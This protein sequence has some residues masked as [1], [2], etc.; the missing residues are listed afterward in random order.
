MGR[1]ERLPN[2][3]SCECCGIFKGS[4]Q[5]RH[6]FIFPDGSQY[7]GEWSCGQAEG[8]GTYV[9]SSGTQYSGQFREGVPDGQGQLAMVNGTVYKGAFSQGQIGGGEGEVK[10]TPGEEG[11]EAAAFEGSFDGAA[12]NGKGVFRYPNQTTTEGSWDSGE[13]EAAEKRAAEKRMKRGGSQRSRDNGGCNGM[14]VTAASFKLHNNAMLDSSQGSIKLRRMAKEDPNASLSPRDQDD[15]DQNLPRDQGSM[16]ITGEDIGGEVVV[17]DI[18]SSGVL[19]N[20]HL[21][22]KEAA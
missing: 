5:G 9:W 20:R 3:V 8:E 21:Q 12:A 10:F 4:L 19:S 22:R 13:S 11:C 18:F 1:F 16:A 14:N 7:D 2:R 17:K 15:G 6:K